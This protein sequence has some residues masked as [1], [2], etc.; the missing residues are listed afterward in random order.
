[1][2]QPSEAI[3]RDYKIQDNKESEPI[4]NYFTC[5]PMIALT[6]LLLISTAF[7]CTAQEKKLKKKRVAPTSP[8]AS[9]LTGKEID[10]LRVDMDNVVKSFEFHPFFEGSELKGTTTTG[11]WKLQGDGKELFLHPRE[12]E[13]GWKRYSAYLWSDKPYRDFVIDF[14]FKFET[15][16]NS[17]FYFRVGDQN[18]PVEGGCE[19]QLNDTHAKGDEINHHDMGGL[20]RAHPAAVNAGKKAGEWNRAIVHVERNR[21]RAYLNGLQIHDIDLS[22]TPLSDRPAIGFIGFQDH[23]LDFWL[24]NVRIAAPTP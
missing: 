15:D 20:L 10:E 1:M 17:G 2:D 11:N 23:G 24:R 22:K 18:D 14:E 5:R 13:E 6:V 4:M 8:E 3:C 21:M 12:G 9:A 7:P 16:G 19:L